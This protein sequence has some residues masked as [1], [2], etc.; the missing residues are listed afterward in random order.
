MRTLGNPAA[1]GNGATALPFHV[2]HGGRAAPEPRCSATTVYSKQSTINKEIMKSSLI[3][4][5][6]LAVGLG[7]L[8]PLAFIVGG[9]LFENSRW[10]TLA[11]YV[12]IAL[13]CTACQFWLPRKG[14][15]GLP[16][17]WPI[18]V[19]IVGGL[20]AARALGM[21]PTWPQFICGCVAAIAGAALSALRGGGVR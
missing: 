2:G 19:G 16:A 8:A 11:G 15:G 10:E 4:R 6:V 17:S 21:F 7:I 5:V 13:Y 9:S 3:G 1:S 20:L 18:L 12:A 14:S